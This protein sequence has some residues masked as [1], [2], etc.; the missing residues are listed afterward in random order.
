MKTSSMA[1]A[2]LCADARSCIEDA[3]WL[4]S[5]RA[6]SSLDPFILLLSTS[7]ADSY[8][9]TTVSL[10]PSLSFVICGPYRLPSS[11]SSAAIKIENFQNPKTRS[12][13]EREKKIQRK[14]LLQQRPHAA[15]S[16]CH[17]LVAHKRSAVPNP[18]ALALTA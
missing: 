6:K 17:C 15:I 12:R 4:S 3:Y 5:A 9:I 7:C 10:C 11:E 14:G 2:Y 18:I 16:F 8:N 13:K 1:R